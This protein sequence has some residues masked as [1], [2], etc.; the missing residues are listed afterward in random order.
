MTIGSY[1]N[2]SIDLRAGGISNPYRV[3]SHQTYVC[4][5]YN[6]IRTGFLSETTDSHT[7]TKHATRT[8][9]FFFQILNAV[10][11]RF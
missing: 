9:F 3:L 7:N 2:F 4:C 6:Q 1:L 8:N 5:Y 11:V 10:C